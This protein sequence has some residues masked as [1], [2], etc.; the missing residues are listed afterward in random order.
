MSITKTAQS[1]NPFAPELILDARATLGEGAFWDTV[2]KRLFWLDILQS[3]LHRFDPATKQDEVFDIG[4]HVGT[5]VTRAKGGVMLAVKRGLASYDLETKTLK[6]VA[7]PEK[8]KPKNRFND[9]K[10]DPKGRF[11]AGTLAYDETV[12]AGA[13]YRLDADGS[14]K[15]MEKNVSCSNGLAWDLWRRLFYFIDSPTR[16]VVAY[17]YNH[18]DGSIENKRIV[19]QAAVEDGFPDG[20]A[21]DVDGKLWVAHWGSSQVIRWDPDTGRA[22]K[23]IKLPVSQ[24]TSCAF[25][26]NRLDKLYITS[27]RIGLTDAQLLKEP[28][29]GGLFVVTPGIL[30][31]EQTA[32][33]G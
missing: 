21:I 17:D 29:A 11:W 12:G 24:V 16:T 2:T 26:G 9:G 27:A 8:D 1:Q 19:V 6:L 7:E 5:V 13:L 15:V 18:A 31:V 30:G 20:M 32:Y 10:C 3:Q 4:E 23:R 22:L 33:A 14:V 28:Q 25:G